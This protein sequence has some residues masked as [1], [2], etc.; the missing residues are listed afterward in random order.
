[1]KEFYD[2]FNEQGSKENANDENGE[3]KVD[4]AV[5]NT[6]TETASNNSNSNSINIDM[7][8]NTS[9]DNS[10]DDD[11]LGNTK[12]D[13]LNMDFDLDMGEWKRIIE[14]NQPQQSQS[15]SQSQ[16]H[17]YSHNHSSETCSTDNANLSKVDKSIKA[18]TDLENHTDQTNL[19][20]LANAA[21][22][23][24]ISP[25]VSRSGSSSPI[26]TAAI[27]KEKAQEGK[28]D[29]TIRVKEKNL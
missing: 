22:T 13:I 27:H 15:Q 1:M 4:D 18:M 12:M 5:N 28:E 26:A 16:H 3:S 20:T 11:G 25:P 14:K 19:D 7:N 9:N 23:G 29:E 8:I 10:D 17:N 6:M 21:A 2:L 24:I